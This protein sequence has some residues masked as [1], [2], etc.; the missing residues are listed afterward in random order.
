MASIAVPAF[1]N[2]RKAAK[3]NAYKTDLTA[4]HKGWQAFGVELD[5][6]CERETSPQ[7]ASITTVGM[8]SL[9]TSKLY[10]DSAVA[11][12][13]HTLKVAGNCTSAPSGCA[14]NA[15]STDCQGTLTGGNHADC[16]TGT[17]SDIF[18]PQTQ[19]PGKENF[20]GFGSQA[21]TGCPGTLSSRQVKKSTTTGDTDW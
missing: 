16:V 6:Y 18:V 21:G 12:C 14:L 1:N 5:S 10:G 8:E 13:D 20:I 2:Y 11:K 15:G 9:L 17:C 4:L 3:K 7:S 19:G